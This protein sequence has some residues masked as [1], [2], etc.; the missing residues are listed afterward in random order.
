LA[1]SKAASHEEFEQEVTDALGEVT[2]DEP[3]VIL[4]LPESTTLMVVGSRRV[5]CAPLSEAVV[6]VEATAQEIG[7]EGLFSSDGAA[8]DVLDVEDVLYRGVPWC[9]VELEP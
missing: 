9:R 7:A 2:D 4:D 1:Q 5:R 3:E 8:L 6:Y